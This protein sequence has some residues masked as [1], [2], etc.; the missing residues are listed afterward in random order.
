M[1]A[2]GRQGQR[3]FVSDTPRHVVRGSIYPSGCGVAPAACTCIPLRCGKASS[4]NPHA[5]DHLPRVF[6]NKS[7]KNRTRSR[8]PISQSLTRDGARAAAAGGSRPRRDLRGRAASGRRSPRQRPTRAERGAGA[9]ALR[10][11][12]RLAALHGRRP[13]G[14]ALARGGAAAAR[15]AAVALAGRCGGALALVPRVR[16]FADE[17]RRGCGRGGAG[18]RKRKLWEGQARSPLSG[19]RAPRPCTLA[20]ARGSPRVAAACCNTLASCAGVGAAT[21]WRGEEE[22]CAAPVAACSPCAL[23]L[24]RLVQASGCCTSGGL[25]ALC[26]APWQAGTGFRACVVGQWHCRSVSGRLR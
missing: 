11:A 23:R 7:R 1:A 19:Q 10:R 4:H 18:K 15:A 6:K 20:R 22:Q 16:G 21:E 8:L 25:L 17:V 2:S 12:A 13:R 3:R 26:L 9:A 24:G 14:M 5:I